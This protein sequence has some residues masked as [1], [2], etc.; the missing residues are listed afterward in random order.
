MFTSHFGVMS[1]LKR[2]SENSIGAPDRN[3]VT[4]NIISTVK[5][6]VFQFG[7]HIYSK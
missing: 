6:I 2:N 5:K 4:N 7:I 3:L 1:Y